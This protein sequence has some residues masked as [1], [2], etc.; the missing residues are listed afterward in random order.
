M[1]ATG[2]LALSLAL[3]GC[4]AAGGNARD[5]GGKSADTPPGVSKNAAGVQALNRNEAVAGGALR[6]GLLAPLES[7]D[8]IAPG[9]SAALALMRPIYDALFVYDAEGNSV[10]E[11]AESLESKDGKTWTLV[12]KPDI[13]FSDG[14][15]YNAEAVRL[16]VERLASPESQSRSAADA[17]NVESMQVQDATTLILTLK[18]ATMRFPKFFT[19][20]I[21]GMGSVVPSPAAVDKF[22]TR[23][24]QNAVGAGPFVLESFQG[25]GA[26]TLRKNP[27]YRIAGLPHLD[28]LVYVPA[29][30]TQARLSAVIAGDLDLAPTQSAVDLKKAEEA[31][32]VTLRQL[33]GTYYNLLFNLKKAP[34][35]DVRFREAVMRAIDLD[36]LNEAVFEGLHTP[37]RGMFPESSPYYLDTDWPGF[38]PER[39]RSLVDAFTA[40]TGNAA[41]FAMTTTSPP[42]F[43]KQAQ[44]MQQ[45]LAD[46]GITMNLNVGDQPTMITEAFAGNYQAQHRFTSVEPEVDQG[47]MGSFLSTSPINNSQA[48]R[49]EVDELLLSLNTDFSPEHKQ[50]VYSELQERFREWLPIVPLIA[51]ENGWYVGANV[52]NAEPFP[53]DREPDVRK[54]WITK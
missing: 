37:M 10:P 26:I 13:T 14:T 15:P 21:Q 50:Q 31:G 22:G 42:E 32:L 17:R 33:K 7:L 52:G 4:A 47:L 19:Y 38:D 12:I 40:E 54:L 43:Q 29:T 11:L 5:E 44:V 25:G 27:T 28:E 51:H 45:M 2:A 53:G 3:T 16:H 35:D 36:A 34:F 1:A 23:L 48:G 8:P 46:V 49:P 9:N 18:Q 24:G 41:E 30:D 6:I 39:A 20:G